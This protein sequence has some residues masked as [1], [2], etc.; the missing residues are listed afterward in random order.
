[1]STLLPNGRVTNYAGGD[2]NPKSTN[3]RQTVNILIR[4]FRAAIL[5]VGI[6]FCVMFGTT[7][8]STAA[9]HSKAAFYNN[10]LSLYQRY[11]NLYRSTGVAQY[12]Y[13]AQAFLYYY[14]AG[15]YGDYNGYYSDP[16]GYKSTTYR[17]SD[18]YAD[19][20]YNTLA[21]YGDYYL[22]L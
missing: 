22:R 7:Q 19:I 16:V 11:L 6:A 20:Y 1:M 13:D 17:G 18:T 12:Y 9:K 15:Y 2:K 14:D 8:Q 3:Q 4:K 21:Y 10:Y 5:V